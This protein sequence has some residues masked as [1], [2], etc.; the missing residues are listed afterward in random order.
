MP[1]DI[2]IDL[3]T[4]NTVV[5]VAGQGIVL[6]EATVIALDERSGDVLAIGHEAFEMAG[7]RPGIAAIRPVR[8]GAITDFDLTERLLRLVL[9]RVGTGRFF[10]PRAIVAVSSGLTAVE[11]RAV[12]EATSSAGARSTLLIEEPVAAAIGAGMP[13]EQPAGNCVIDIGGGTT[14][15]AV[16]AMGG[17][18]SLAAEPVGGFE[19]DE[20]IREFLRAEHGVTITD[21]MAEEVKR[22]VGSA[23]PTEDEPKAE[24]NGRDLASGSPRAAIVSAEE[25]RAALDPVI[26]RIIDAVRR[27]LAATPPDLAHDVLER[28]MVLTG[29]GALLR[30]LDA[31][32]EAETDIPVH[33]AER[34]HT[35]VCEGAAAALAASDK[36]K[37]HGIFLHP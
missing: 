35:T 27:A 31:R 36:L 29:G 24:I 3:G 9:A 2:A 16:I 25:I 30:G 21:R 14:E 7:R 28:G 4:A 5:A 8:H 12:M 23:A 19:A 13:I 6:D 1:R 20:A 33:I 18:V 37:H 26:T 10:H 34:P 17:L 11:Q 32:I 22:T 15:V